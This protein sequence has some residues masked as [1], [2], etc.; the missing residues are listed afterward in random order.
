MPSNLTQ[1]PPACWPAGVFSGSNIL[2]GGVGIF[3]RGGDVAV[4]AVVEV[5]VNSEVLFITKDESQCPRLKSR[6]KKI[7]HGN[8]QWPVLE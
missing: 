3:D 5:L 2:Q 8:G 1:L 7:D 6:L 4:I